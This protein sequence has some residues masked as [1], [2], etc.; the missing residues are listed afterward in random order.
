MIATGTEVVTLP[1]DLRPRDSWFAGQ[2]LGGQCLDGRAD[3]KEPGH[4]CVE[5]QAVTCT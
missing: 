2:Q 4:D 1:R 3:L 5:D